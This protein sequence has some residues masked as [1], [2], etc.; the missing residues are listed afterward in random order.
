VRCPLTDRLGY[1]IQSA[2]WSLCAYGA[3][4]VSMP[5]N[6]GICHE[7]FTYYG[8]GHLNSFGIMC[9]C[10]YRDVL[11]SGRITPDGVLHAGPRTITTQDQV[12]RLR[13]QGTV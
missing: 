7:L 2:A 10:V 6:H 4:I 5:G 12:E 13:E 1:V 11:I 3:T 8:V 9:V